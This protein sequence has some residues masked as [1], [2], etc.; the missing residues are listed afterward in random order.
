MNRDEEHL[1]L[2]GVFHYV[3]AALVALLACFPIIHL[4]FGLIMVF[5]PESMDHGKGPPT[6]PFVAA[7]GWF[8]V[9]FAAATI[10][11]GWAYAGALVY[12]GHCLRRRR[13]RLFCII[14]GGLS[15]MFF[16][17]GTVLGVFTLVV[18]IRPSVAA[19]FEGAPLPPATGSRAN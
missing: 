17:F 18:L 2:L 5:A 19:L 7:F 1:N 11:L 16:P 3:V 12:A 13:Q 10:A 6:P 8:F 15:C 14:M 9:V 4:I